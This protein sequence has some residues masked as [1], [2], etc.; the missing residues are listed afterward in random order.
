MT[1]LYVARR[2]RRVPAQGRAKRH[3]T[4]ASLTGDY[5]HMTSDCASRRAHR[6]A[7]AGLLSTPALSL[8]ACTGLQPHASTPDALPQRVELESGG[9]KALNYTPW[10]IHSFEIA[11]PPGPGIGGGGP[12]VMPIH[13]DGSP[14]GGGAETC[15][16][17]FPVDWQPDLKLTVRWLADKKQ[18]GKTP[19]Y[20]YKSENVRIAQYGR[21][22]Y[23]VWGIFLPGDRI[24]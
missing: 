5:G 4:R 24:R 18:D 9:T 17:S 2:I 16:T 1:L 3:G 19:G 6:A 10:Y 21:E 12:N 22:T 20:W 14:S 15:C 23:A 8:A 13:K 11:G 7:T